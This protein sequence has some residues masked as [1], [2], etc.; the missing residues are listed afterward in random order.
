MVEEIGERCGTYCRD[1]VIVTRPLRRRLRPLPCR[2]EFRLRRT[3]R[4]AERPG[5]YAFVTQVDVAGEAPWTRT[6]DLVPW[7]G[8]HRCHGYG[9]HGAVRPGMRPGTLSSSSVTA[10]GP[11]RGDRRESSMG[12]HSR[13]LVTP[14]AAPAACRAFGATHVVADRGDAASR[15]RGD[16]HGMGRMLVLEW[17]EPP[18]DV[19]S[20]RAVRPGAIVSPSGRDGSSCHRPN[21][22]GTWALGGWRSCAISS[23]LLDW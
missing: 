17:S 14:R 7:P 5:E 19:H 10:R 21:S 3:R 4:H 6:P 8:A 16:D 22:R 2:R 11:L 20:G 9:S 15:C 18:S 1:F 12:A 13:G 23:D